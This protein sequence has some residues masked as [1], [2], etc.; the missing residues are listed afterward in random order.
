[1]LNTDGHPVPKFI[2]NAIGQ[3]SQ[4]FVKTFILLIVREIFI[5]YF[6]ILVSYDGH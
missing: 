3:G 1:M 5:K 4:T 6:G 2:L